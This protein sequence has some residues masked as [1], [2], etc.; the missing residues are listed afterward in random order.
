MKKINL[1]MLLLFSITISAQSVVEITYLDI[2]ATKIAD[3]V[4]AHKKITDMSQDEN[5]TIKASWVYRHWYGSGA[6]IVIYDLY[7]SAE[8]AIKDDLFAALNKNVK[9]LTEEE[10]KEI[11]KTFDLWWAGF[12]NHWDEM[13]NINIEKYYVFKENADWDIPFVYVEG[14]YNSSGSFTDLADAFMEWS[15]KPGVKDGLMLGGG[16]S[17]HYKGTGNDVQFFSAYKDIMDFAKAVS[18]SG[19]DNSEARSKFWSLVDGSH[20]DQILIHVGHLEN[21]V[22]NLAGKD[23]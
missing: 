9:K 7:D 18:S 8:D 13:R 2:P 21:G 16:A 15:I 20:N 6:S 14:N 12:D 17:F 10:Q 4:Q 11:T 23:N 22:F 5:R 1:I 19:S 3:F